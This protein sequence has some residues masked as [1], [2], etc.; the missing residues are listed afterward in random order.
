MSVCFAL[1]VFLDC[2]A[3][4]ESAGEAKAGEVKTG[5]KDSRPK[6]AEKRGSELFFIRIDLCNGRRS[7][8]ERRKI[9]DS[10]CP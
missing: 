4:T 1:E 9:G 6:R 2:V 8:V 7:N 5:V 3:D 10:K